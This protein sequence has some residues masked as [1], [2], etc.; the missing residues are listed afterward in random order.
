ME[1][2]ERGNL[3]FCEHPKCKEGGV[4]LK[5][6]DHFSNHVQSVQG[7]PECYAHQDMPMLSL[8]QNKP[9]DTVMAAL[10]QSKGVDMLSLRCSL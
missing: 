6:L 7:D 5:H 10:L 4:K 9:N 3:I 2:R 8:E 1:E